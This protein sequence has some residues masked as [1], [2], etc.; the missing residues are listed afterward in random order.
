MVYTF[1]PKLAL[2]TSERTKDQFREEMDKL[3]EMARH[4]TRVKQGKYQAVY[5]LLKGEHTIDF[6]NM[7]SFRTL[8]KTLGYESDNLTQLLEKLELEDFEHFDFI[9]NITEIIIQ[10]Y[11][12]AETKIRIDAIDEVS[13]NNYQQLKTDLVY[14]TIDNLLSA[15]LQYILVKK[16]IDPNL[17]GLSQEEQQQVLQQIEQ[18]KQQYSLNSIE[19]KLRS[20]Y[21]NLAIEFAQK[22]KKEDEERFRFAEIIRVAML[23]FLVSGSYFIHN[24]IGLDYY[25]PEV[26]RQY[27]VFTEISDDETNPQRAEII[28]R[29]RWMRANDIIQDYGIF[30]TDKQQEALINRSTYSISDDIEHL[31]IEEYLRTSGGNVYLDF[32]ERQAANRLRN[33]SNQVGEETFEAVFGLKT[34]SHDFTLATSGANFYGRTLYDR[35]EVTEGYYTTYKMVGFVRYEKDGEVF[36]EIVTDELMKDFKDI[37]QLKL[38]RVNALEFTNSEENNIIVW[39]WMPE[40]RWG[41][42]I[43]Q[44]NTQMDDAIYI[45]GDKL[46]HK[47]TRDSKFYGELVPVSGVI[48]KKSRI[49]QIAQH[50]SWYN[51]IMNDAKMSMERNLGFLTFIDYRYISGN[52]KGDGGEDTFNNFFSL[53]KHWGFVPL[54]YSSENI[55]GTQIQTQPFNVVNASNVQ[56]TQQKLQFAKYFKAEAYNELG[57]GHLLQSAPLVQEQNGNEMT[58][59]QSSAMLETIYDEFTEGLLGFWEMHI[60]YAKFAKINKIDTSDLYSQSDELQAYLDNTDLEIANSELRM[61]AMNNASER[62]KLL[63]AKQV[64]LMNTVEASFEE[65]LEILNSSSMAEIIDKARILE[66]KRMMIAQQNQEYEK[67]L[68]AQKDEAKAQ[69]L[70]QEHQN[71][72]NEIE[73][74]GKMEIQ[75]ASMMATGFQKDPNNIDDIIKNMKITLNIAEQQAN[76]MMNQQKLAFEELKFDDKKSKEDRKLELKERELDIKEKMADN[77]LAIAAVNK[78]KYDMPSN[79]NK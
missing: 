4:Q 66:E 54:D 3:E 12:E 37:Y 20:S 15:Q 11:L 77:Q 56:E 47:V 27:D 70:L 72:M 26:W 49:K 21:K 9:G 14:E 39:Q 17:E 8:G 32:P 29:R 75:K 30:L 50:Q 42:K 13:M 2:K 35:F 31:S 67:Q 24:K 76:E 59:I 36:Q 22:T 73:L 60:E 55:Q 10:T 23:D 16:G 79:A 57:I 45:G 71:R 28:G 41:L 19:Q 74:K 51:M 65:R 68:Q 48:N 5:K 34:P 25:K 38:K 6:D 69:L 1:A 33:L 53:A 43:N 40:K 63:E 61:Y 58:T 18:V 62:R 52:Y 7:K 46:V 64:V 78:N 44:W